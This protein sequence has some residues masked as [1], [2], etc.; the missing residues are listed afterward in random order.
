M[1]LPLARSLIQKV[2]DRARETGLSV[3]V[4][5]ADE[6]GNPVAIERMDGAFLASFDIALNKAYTA[7]ALRMSTLS[8]KP[9]AQ[10]GGQLY[11]IQHTNGGKIVVFGGGVPL[12][13]SGR[14]I[15]GLGVSGG[16]EAQDSALAEY[17]ASILEEE[18]SC[19]LTKRN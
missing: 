14:L 6:G 16:T 2:Q 4:A 9:M 15:G 1:D 13:K 11:G 10:P 8:L 17:G 5:V 18:I 7:C 19:R 12:M 3:V